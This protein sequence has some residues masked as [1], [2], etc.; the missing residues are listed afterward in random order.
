MHALR[1]TW[2]FVN[3]N[4][5]YYQHSAEA[6]EEQLALPVSVTEAP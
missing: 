1:R 6:A 5:R 3:N 2:T 4:C